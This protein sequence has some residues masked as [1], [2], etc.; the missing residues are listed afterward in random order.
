MDINTKILL[1]IRRG[2]ATGKQSQNYE[3][4][5]CPDISFVKSSES[6]NFENKSVYITNLLQHPNSVGKTNEPT[7]AKEI[8]LQSNRR[9]A[10][11]DFLIC[12]SVLCNADV[13]VEK[14]ESFWRTIIQNCI[15]I[16]YDLRCI[17]ASCTV[18]M[19][20]R[21]LIQTIGRS[22]KQI[23]LGT[24]KKVR[25]YFRAHPELVSQHMPMRP[26]T[27]SSRCIP[28]ESPEHAKWY[29]GTVYLWEEEYKYYYNTTLENLELDRIGSVSYPYKCMGCAVWAAR[30]LCTYFN[31]AGVEPVG[32]GLSTEKIILAVAKQCGDAR[33]NCAVTAAVLA[34]ADV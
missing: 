31:K 28:Y 15:T 23:I 14:S 3:R 10:T 4:R 26:V 9:V 5:R 29:D 30:I 32:P 19:L 2:Y 13:F 22:R 34:A 25:N 16:T 6:E 18:A 27:D 24:Y 1:A 11:N 33:M 7:A 12:A 21:K 8:W 20:I 17:I